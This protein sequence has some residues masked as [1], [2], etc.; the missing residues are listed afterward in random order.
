MKDGQA[1]VSELK[2]G[3]YYL[4]EIEAPEGYLLSDKKY[5]V[6]LSSTDQTEDVTDT[7]ITGRI[8]IH[9]TYGTEKLPEKSAEFALY[10]SNNEKVDTLIIDENGDALSREL[11]YGNYRIEQTKGMDGYAFLPTQII[12][13]DALKPNIRSMQTMNRNMPV[14]PFQKPYIVMIRKRT[15]YGMKPRRMQNL[16]SRMPLE[17][18]GNTSDG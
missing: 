2:P 12:K 11:P 6:D 17:N 13:I 18:S 9:K 7:L 15:A 14:L 5:P 4:Q 3:K 16:R 1:A 8:S 10:N